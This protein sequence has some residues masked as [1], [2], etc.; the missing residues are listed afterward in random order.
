MLKWLYAFMLRTY[1]A[2]N[3]VI[4]IMPHGNIAAARVAIL[5]CTKDGAAFIDD[6]LKS[7]AGQTHENWMLIVSDD[8]SNDGTV[9]KLERFAEVSPSKNHD[10]E[11]AGQGGLREL[12]FA[13][14]RS[15]NRCGLLR[16]QR[17]RRYLASRQASA[18][19]S[20]PCCRSHRR[21]WHVL[22][23]DRSDDD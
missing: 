22:R 1:K 13:G 14:E 7:I 6:Q 18:R 4:A 16:L 3:E 15:D 2:D 23:S 5:M 12:P 10:Q 11:G 19:V 21:A 9:A 8:G 20:L 17:S